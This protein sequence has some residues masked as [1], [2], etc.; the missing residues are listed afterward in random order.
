MANDASFDEFAKRM[1]LLADQIPFKVNAIK[2]KIALD[3]L[4]NVV[5]ATPVDTGRARNNWFVSLNHAI[6]KVIWGS[7]DRDAAKGLFDEAG[8]VAVKSGEAEIGHARPDMTIVL[9]NNLPYIQA[10]NNGWSKQAPRM[11]VQIAIQR[12]IAPLVNAGTLELRL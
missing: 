7:K 9:Q 6:P 8:T 3:I 11:F 12:V 10:L 5:L 1:G 4:R 2:R